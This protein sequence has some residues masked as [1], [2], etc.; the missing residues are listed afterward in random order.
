MKI[1][2]RV[3]VALVLTLLA[4]NILALY[5]IQE[6]E[7]QA[8]A[9]LRQESESAHRGALLF[10]SLCSACHGKDGKGQVGPS[11]L[12]PDLLKRHE[13]KEGDADDLKKAQTLITKTI[14]R[15]RSN[16][17]MP[18]WSDEEGG[19]LNQ[20]QIYELMTFLVHGTAEDWKEA[21]E[22]APNTPAP[23]ASATG[24]E[25][26]E[27]GKALFAAKGCSSCHGAN[28]EGG[29]GP[30]LAGY[31]GQQVTKQVRTP[32]DKMPSFPPDRLSDDELKQIIAFVE[33]LK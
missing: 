28:A 8:L 1:D 21:I 12:L 11:L 2:K 19:S 6:P 17:V 32:K 3:V 30:K 13:Y 14:A 24:A 18:A 29:V 23:A 9:A 16:T 31:T 27:A 4:F 25:G 33:R 5:A 15:G 22:H 7:R 20:E 10:G 26:P